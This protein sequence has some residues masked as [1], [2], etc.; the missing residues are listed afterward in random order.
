M[1]PI[2]FYEGNN[3]VTELAITSLD[4]ENQV[5]NLEFSTLFSKKEHYETL[6]N[7]KF[8][9]DQNLLL[10]ITRN[11]EPLAEIRLLNVTEAA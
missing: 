1:R 7:F 6:K 11:G 8:N 3:Y 2:D 9:F 10:N 4:T 5:E